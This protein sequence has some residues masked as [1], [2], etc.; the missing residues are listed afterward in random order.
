[1]T[2]P[3]RDAAPR[4]PQPPPGGHCTCRARDLFRETVFAVALLGGFLGGTL[5]LLAAWFVTY[6]AR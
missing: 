4:P 5:A 2:P 3:M 6:A 1:M